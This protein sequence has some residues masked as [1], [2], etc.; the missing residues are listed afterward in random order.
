MAN[1]V[2]E[3]P[4]CSKPVMAS[5][6]LFAK[7]KL[8]CSCGYEINV[9]AERIETKICARCGNQVLVDRTRPEKATCPICHEKINAGKLVKITCP[10]C[11]TELSVDDNAPTCNCP[12]C[13]TFINIQ[14]RIQQA[15]KE[16][17]VE[18]I[19]WEGGQNNIFVYKHPV[20]NFGFGSMLT[21]KEGQKAIFFRDGRGLDIFGPGRHVL[22]TENIP[23]MASEFATGQD[24]FF[25]A[26]VYFIRTNRLDIKWGL[27]ETEYK[28]PLLNF[29]VKMYSRG[30]ATIQVQEDDSSIRKFLYMMMDASDGNSGSAHGGG[31]SYDTDYIQNRFRSFIAARFSDLITQVMMENG[32]GILDMNSKKSVVAKLLCPKLNAVLNDYGLYIPNDELFLID[33]IGYVDSPEIQRWKQQESE[34]TIRTREERLQED[35]LRASQGRIR[36][37]EENAALRGVLHSQAEGEIGK[38]KAQAAVDVSKI[39][40]EGRADV[41]LIDT[42]AEAKSVRI[43]ALG[44]ADAMRIIAQGEG[45]A[46]SLRAPG[47]AEAMVTLARAEG[48][49]SKQRAL[50]DSEAIR[51]TGGA[52]AEAYKAQALAEAEE[53]RAKGYTY[54]QETSRQVGLEAMKNGLPGTGSAGGN[55]GVS[56]SLGNIMGLGLELGTMGSVMGM[57]K[58]M[59]SPVLS[60]STSIGQGFIG[61]GAATGISNGWNCSCGQSNITSKFCPDCGQPMPVKQVTWTCPNCGK[62]GIESRFCPDCGSKKGE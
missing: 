11:Y 45:E 31:E 57:A 46:E 44:E 47:Q 40:A 56:S 39:S 17:K 33:T 7:K 48:E 60:E 54:A 27:P 4:A 49:S 62:S 59:I 12:Q 2:I 21:V 6:G 22:E 52:T 13:N 23:G 15:D 50:G 8:K 16:G 14:A 41:K 26:Q 35:V 61:N 10:S 1:M 43:S 32:I 58:E 42:E 37:E 9:A 20:E 29:Y 28:D 30:T 24:L 25:S 53:M 51:L 36:A 55:N 5:T 3:C 38:I 18:H 34:R 19:R